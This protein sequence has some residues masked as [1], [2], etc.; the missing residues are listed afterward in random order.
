MPAARPM[1]RPWK[2]PSFPFIFEINTWP[3]LEHVGR[4]ESATFD[5]STVPDTYWDALADL[6]FDAVWLMGVWQRSR[7]GV[8]LALA[9][10]GLVES[11][12]RALPDYQPAD[13]VGSPYCI[14]GY[15]VADHLGGP[16]G[17]AVA[18][19]ALAERGMGLILDFV[20]N[21]V[22][23][24]HPWTESHPERFIH[25]T[26][27]DLERDPA[28]FVRVGD[29]VIANGR[30]PYFAAWPDVVQLNAFSTDLRTAVID[31]LRSIAD[32][33]DAVRCDMAMLMIN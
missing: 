6:G 1:R 21:H 14:R 2:P 19:R 33:C 26:Q 17:L 10:A 20:P 30:D 16:E 31:T 5:L 7:T 32:Q 25:G 23:P 8:E 3:W 27:D 15:T 9:N 11:F 12:Q 4:T 13:V 28:S 18:R 29:A 22:A 24:D